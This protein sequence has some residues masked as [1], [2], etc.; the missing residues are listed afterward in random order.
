MTIK[1]KLLLESLQACMPGIESGNTTI[2]GAD[3]FVF[4]D[5]KIFSY[6][7]AIS[8]AV[9]L[10][11]IG[12]VDET[13]EGAVHA[14]E[15]FKVISKFTGEEINFAP[16]NNSWMLKCGKAKVEMT[17]LDFNYKNRLEG[18]A[19][20]EDWI[21]IDD[22]FI[23]GVG[24]CKMLNNKTLLSGIY[25]SGKQII[26]TDGFQVNSFE[27]KDVELPTFWISDNSANELLKTKNFVSAQLQGTWVHFK[28]SNGTIF[29]IKTLQVEKF[30]IDKI[31]N[32]LNTANPK[33]NDFHAT[34]PVELFNA[35][36]RA[37]SFSI[38]ISEHSAV[39][40]NI[41][42]ENIVVSAERTSG[43]YSEKVAWEE[44][45][46]EE[47]DSIV[48]YVDSTMMSFMAKRTLEFYIQK[49]T[50][51]EG[52]EIPRLLFVSDYSKHMMSTFS[53]DA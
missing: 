43:K 37:T 44:P 30:P 47:F 28:S 50:S 3:A 38:E 11:E 16:N 51:C 46:E 13:L 9:P 52:K 49:F 39:R 29:S 40:L 23:V 15:F 6:N 24:T 26:S 45:I 19:P 10:G 18:I 7:D 27:M 21:D 17:L 31:L 5:G 14:D 25:V 33:E 53:P 42:K 48:V 8:V 4:H 36:D 2:Q 32:L 20:S 34:F 41:S 22:D 12:L 1:R 35:I